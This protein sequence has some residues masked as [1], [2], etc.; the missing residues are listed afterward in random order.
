MRLVPHVHIQAYVS[1][2]TGRD[3]LVSFSH[4]TEMSEVELIRRQDEG[5]RKDIV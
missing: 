2:Y 3:N 5:A 1:A 4:T